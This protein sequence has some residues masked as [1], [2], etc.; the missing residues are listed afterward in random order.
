MTIY[1]E[2]YIITDDKSKMNPTMIYDML[3]ET[4][5]ASKRSLSTIQ[6][7]I[8]GAICFGVFKDQQQVGFARIITDHATMYWLCD[9]II[10]EDHRG[11]GLG[12]A[13]VGVIVEDDRFKHLTGILATKDA[14]KLYQKYGF[15]VVDGKYMRKLVD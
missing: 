2:D 1:H 14:H 8:D 11:H 15:I 9:V 13:L 4:Y 7:S 10:H 6:K 12:Q 3:H 5:W